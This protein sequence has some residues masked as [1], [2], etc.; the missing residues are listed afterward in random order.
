[1]KPIFILPTGYAA[2]NMELALTKSRD[3]WYFVGE[4]NGYTV[5]ARKPNG[6]LFFDGEPMKTRQD[7]AIMAR[8]L[9]FPTYK[10]WNGRK[11]AYDGAGEITLATA[12]IA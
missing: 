3:G 12:R 5:P 11:R 6:N 10:V 9:E 7:A 1:M 2:R 4:A 8:A